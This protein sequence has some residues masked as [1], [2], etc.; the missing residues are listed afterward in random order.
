MPRSPLVTAGTAVVF[1]GA[2]VTGFA[3]G[4]TARGGEADVTSPTVPTVSSVSSSSAPEATAGS[5][6]STGTGTSPATG[7]S[8]APATSP[9]PSN[10]D[11]VAWIA[12]PAVGIRTALGPGGLSEDGTI[13]PPAG[14]VMWFTG[15]GRVM[16]GLVGT[17]VVAGHVEADGRPDVFSRLPELRTGQR[18]RVGYKDGDV[19]DMKVV[20]AEVVDK[21]RLQHDPDVWGSNDSTRRVA[22]I[23]CDDALGFRSDG[24]RVANFVAI[25]ERA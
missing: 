10:R 12:V 15:H 3:L 7:S 2:V 11:R 20:R 21:G 1:L 17:S 9:L 23:T 6:G 25:A 18:V 5:T 4:T 13:S 24:H 19:L 22:L 8:Q 16:P 14:H